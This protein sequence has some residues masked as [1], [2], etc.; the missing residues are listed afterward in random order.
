M[1]TLTLVAL[2]L[3]AAFLFRA[4][5]DFPAWG[6]PASP[7]GL[8]VSRFF[9]ERSYDDA[10]TPNLVTATLADYRSYDTMFETVVVF[11]AALA[12]FFII[13]AAREA[14]VANVFHYRHAPTG[15]VLTLRRGCPLPRLRGRFEQIDSEWTPRSVILETVSRGMIPFLQLFAIYVLAHGHYSPGGGFQAGVIFGASYILL[16][17][18]HDLRTLTD[19]VAERTMHL[20]AAA[21][22]S[23]YVGIG[24]LA[25]WAGMQFMDYGWMTLAFGMDGP[26]AHSLGI[27]LVELGVALTVCASLTTIFKLVSSEGTIMEGL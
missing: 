1:R 22:V 26:G 10:R 13:R 7:A 8:H 4:A 6:D 17:V 19:H 23:L 24:A 21:G 3:T 12:C 5:L 18:S 27:L 15:L 14:C 2:T 11:C 9:I 16:A 25:L 20:L